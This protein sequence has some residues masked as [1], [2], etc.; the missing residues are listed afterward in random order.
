MLIIGVD[1]HPSLQHIAFVDTD[2]GESG[3]RR[4]MHST[5]EAEAFYREL[6]KANLKVRAGMEATGRTRRFEDLLAELGFE[7]WIGIPAKSER[8]GSGSRRQIAIS[9]IRISPWLNDKQPAPHE[10]LG[11]TRREPSRDTQAQ[12]RPAQRFQTKSV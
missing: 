3:E 4:L 10:T 5:G 6:Q 11:S 8:G 12:R 9:L 7:L 1:Y 2:T